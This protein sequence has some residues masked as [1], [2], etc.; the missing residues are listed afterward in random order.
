LFY[1][2]YYLSCP[3]DHYQSAHAILDD[4]ENFLVSFVADRSNLVEIRA[5]TFASHYLMPPDFLRKI[6][7]SCD[8]NTE[9]AID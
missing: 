9:K 3:L 8:W 5:N 7:D 2:F 6:P 4:E 1:P